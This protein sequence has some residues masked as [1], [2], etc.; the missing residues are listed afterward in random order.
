ME[1]STPML[2]CGKV[3]STG[4]PCMM[5]PSHLFNVAAN[6]RGIEISIQRDAMSL[7]S[8]LHIDIFNVWGIDF[9]GSFTNSEG[10]GYILVAVDYASKWVQALPCRAS[11]AMHSK[12][13]FH[14]VIFLRYGVPR[15][16]ISDG[17]SHLIDRTF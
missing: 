4:P 5:M 2:R 12:K 1:L 9:M 15:L 17:G 10:R 7:T 13:M 16:V 14:E 11:V 8:N 3:V 6:V